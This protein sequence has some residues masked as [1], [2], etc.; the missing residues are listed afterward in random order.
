MS[1][2]LPNPVIPDLLGDLIVRMGFNDTGRD[3]TPVVF[4]IVTILSWPLAYSLRHIRS[5]RIKM[6]LSMS[7]GVT[8]MFFIYGRETTLLY[9]AFIISSYLP[10]RYGLLGPGVFTVLVLVTLG[11]IHY[12]SMLTGTATDRMSYT[13]TLMM[14]AAKVS[15]FAFH[16][17]DGRKIRSKQPLSPHAHIALHRE[18]TA[19]VS[20]V[21]SF[22]YLCYNFEFMGSIVG[23]LFTYNEYMDF[24]HAR[25]DFAKVKSVPVLVPIL[26]ALVRAVTVLAAYMYLISLPVI[27]INTLTSAGF[28]TLPLYQRV[29]VSPFIVVACRFAY[30]AVWALSEVSC[31]LSGLAYQPP[32]QFDRGTNVNIIKF[33]LSHN[34]NQVTNNWNIR[35][36][37][38]WL[39]HCIYQRVDSV[40]S[41]IRRLGVGRQAL[42]NLTTKITSAVWHGWFAGYGI[43]FLSLGLGN[44][45]ETLVRRKLHPWLPARFL[46]SHLC[47]V[48]AWAHTWWSLNVFFA[49][50]LSLTW[51]KARLYYDSIYWCMHLYHF[52]IIVVMTLLPTRRVKGTS[53]HKHQ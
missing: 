33:E 14:M 7:V 9:L 11:A 15:M 29:F 19:I 4:V 35:I 36:S 5:P 25:G 16:I 51:E 23:P 1:L 22:E 24:I 50:F 32:N 6:T 3:L 20:D 52:G 41:I 44:W 21:S 26:K 46:N 12:D 38:L 2:P 8:S 40:P 45:T 47:S 10:C 42:A 53:P 34:F 13:G 30:F 48:L 27:N 17:S 43:S 37:D 39:K 18:A 28:L 49:P 31:T